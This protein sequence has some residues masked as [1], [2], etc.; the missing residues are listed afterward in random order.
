LKRVDNPRNEFRC[1]LSIELCEFSEDRG[2][3]KVGVSGEDER[4]LVWLNRE[5]GNGEGFAER[6]ENDPIRPEDV[7]FD[8]FAGVEGGGDGSSG[9][10]AGVV[11]V[12]N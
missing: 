10:D 3:R 8:G 7:S 12:G 11:G 1:R 2:G 9:L 6:R 5:H 4:D